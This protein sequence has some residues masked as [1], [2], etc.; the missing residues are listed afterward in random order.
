M[1]KQYKDTNYQVTENGEVRSLD[2]LT[3]QKTNNAWFIKKG[4][5]LKPGINSCGYK[6]VSITHNDKRI[7]KCIHTLVAETYLGNRPLGYFIN[8]I[9]GNKLNNHYSN[10]EYVTPKENINHAWKI[11]LAKPRYGEKNGYSKL[12]NLAINDIH[13]LRKFGLR[14]NIIAD[15]L[16]VSQQTVSAVLCGKVWNKAI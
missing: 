9:D 11:G 14:Q 10:L 12:N 15:I 13:A 1:W 16:N 7:T 3:F 8:H 4:V 6:C 5:A 2:K